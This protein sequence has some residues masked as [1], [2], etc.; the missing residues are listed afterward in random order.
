M[1]LRCGA[2]SVL[3]VSL[4]VW[5]WSHQALAQSEG[6]EGNR[7][8]KGTLNAC[9]ATGG[10]NTYLCDLDP[11]IAVYRQGVFYYFKANAANTGAATLNIDSRGATPLKKFVN[12]IST[13]LVANDLRANQWVQVIYDGTNF[14]VLSPVN[15]TETGTGDVVKA[16]NP[17]LT[18]P[19]IAALPNLTSNGV[20]T[21]SGGVGTLGVDTG[22]FTKTIASGA[23]AL[24]TSAIA[25]GT[26]A[27]P[28]TV[29]ATG[30]ATTDAILASFNANITGVT[31]YTA[32]T[33][34]TLRVDVYPTINTV[35]I[36]V[37]N[38]TAASITPGA[39]TLNWRVVR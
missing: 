9:V 14:Q 10:T 35:N 34:G 21:T 5:G 16:T 27:T 4:L 25:S 6:I 2:L 22:T 33:S 38:A 39:V 20:V 15:W 12:G 36:V 23:T 28:Q 11:D 24:A 1:N 13:D 8:I 18:G 17:T 37:C 29:S 19:S 30:V 7:V 32:A 31:G 26:C 3:W